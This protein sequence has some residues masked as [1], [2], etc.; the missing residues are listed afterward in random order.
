MI[1]VVLAVAVA[2]ILI[3]LHLAWVLFVLAV[4]GYLGLRAGT[5]WGFW[6][7]AEYERRQRHYRA[8]RWRH[9]N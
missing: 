1:F 7:L 4:G 2:Y 8:R 3:K 6:R 5:W 9:G